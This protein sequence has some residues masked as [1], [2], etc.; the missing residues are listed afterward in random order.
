MGRVPCSLDSKSPNCPERDAKKDPGEKSSSERDCI[1]LTLCGVWC[2]ST[3]AS[4][5]GW[6][7]LVSGRKLAFEIKDTSI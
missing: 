4:R 7:I 5:T 3:E 1:V 6:S 2:W